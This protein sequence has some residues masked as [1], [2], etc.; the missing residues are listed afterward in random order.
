[1]RYA[2]A[3]RTAELTQSN[4]LLTSEIEE[5]RRAGLELKLSQASFTSI[6]DESKEGIIIIDH[7]RAIRYCNTAARQFFGNSAEQLAAHRFS[8]QLDKNGV[9]ELEI[10]RAEGGV[11]PWKCISPTLIGMEHR[12]T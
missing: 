2:F 10:T 7:E 4:E 8:M 12:H 9:K 11:D 6:V 5:R 3:N 1:M